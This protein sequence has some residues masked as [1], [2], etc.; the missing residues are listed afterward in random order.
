ML[1]WM[2]ERLQSP[3]PYPKY[4]QLLLLPSCNGEHLSGGWGDRWVTDER[5]HSELGWLVDLI[6]VHEM[7]H[8][9]FGDAV[10]I[11]D[12]AHAWLKEGWA[13]YIE[14]VWQ[15]E[16]VS[17]DEAHLHLAE[18]ARAYCTESDE[19]YA[20]PIVTRHFESGGDMYDRLLYPGGAWRIHMLRTNW[21]IPFSGPQS[22][23]I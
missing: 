10:V 1:D 18:K 20:R 8:T 11:R 2:T 4:Y 12:F 5:L 3:L 13:T 15:E 22:L 19:R 16:T 14:V 17:L 21:G 6:N 7:A 9:W 23:I